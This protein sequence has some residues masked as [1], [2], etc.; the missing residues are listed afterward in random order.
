MA[1]KIREVIMQTAQRIVREYVQR[2]HI[3]PQETQTPK[4]LRVAAYCRVSTDSEE[5]LN[6]YSTQ[7]NY[8]TNYI[9]SK[10]EW[11]FVGIYADEGITGTSAKKRKEF[12]RMINDHEWQNRPNNSKSVSVRQEHGG[13]LVKR[14]NVKERASRYSSRRNI[15]SLDPK[16]DMI[17]SYISLAEEESRSIST[18]IRWSVQKRFEKGKVIM[19]FNC[20]YGYGQDKDG[21]GYIKEDEAEVVR[22]IYFGFLIGKSY[23]NI[24]DELRSR[25]IPS[26][27]GNNIWSKSTIKSMI[28]NEKYMGD[29]ILQKTYKEILT[30]A[31]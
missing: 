31:G 18:N 9:K 5:Q 14:E 3:N 17:L 11:E 20:L 13:Q 24:V 4:K 19:C 22:D 16:C 2:G 28:Q 10:P 29:A 1:E 30:N 7:V 23:Q 6:S 25:N 27:K 12:M 21:N 26:P 8:Y 15:D